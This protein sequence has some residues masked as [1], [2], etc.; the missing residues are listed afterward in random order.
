MAISMGAAILG[1]AV[2]GTGASLY[3]SSQA[4]KAAGKAA[5]QNAAL[6]R[7]QYLQTRADLSP[8]SSTLAPT[9]AALSQRL[10]VSGGG[11]AAA[12]GAAPAP[13]GGSYTGGAQFLPGSLTPAGAQGFSSAD[14]AAIRQ[15]WPGIEQEFN[16][17]SASADPNSP[18][19]QQTGADS[20][21]NFTTA[22]YDQRRN[23]ADYTYTPQG[24]QQ[25]AGTQAAGAGQADVPGQ[26]LQ[27]YTRQDATRPG[28][29]QAE[30][31]Y[32]TPQ[33]PNLSG[34]AYRGSEYYQLGLADDLANVNNSFA[35]RGLL[36]SGGALKGF[37]EASANNFNKN[38]GNWANQQLGVWQTNLNQFNADR[39]AGLGQYNLNRNVFNQNFDTD[40]TRTDNI[41]ESDRAYDTNRYDTQTGNLFNLANMGQ[42][43]AA[44][45]ANAGSNYAAAATANNNSRAS[46][47]GNAAI[48]G[49]NGI[50]NLINTGL[51]AY[52]MSQ[53][54]FATSGGGFQVSPAGG[55]GF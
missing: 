25:A 29:S 52:G 43:A 30:P 4:S 35:A 24:Q 26:T 6:Q 51:T 20:L 15:D 39:A 36:K 41:F 28:F 32:S 2:L 31:T 1:S 16:R 47:Q 12:G 45:Q 11:G 27:T 55:W 18:Q 38:Y 44:G 22:W 5:D 42:S 7:E 17:V 48:A 8:A 37:Q 3:G 49:A 21:D 23:P 54:P 13:G 10:G 19:F 53:N 33:G 34:D 9:M 14:L 46:V 50:N 40:R